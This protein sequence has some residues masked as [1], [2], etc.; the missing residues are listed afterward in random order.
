MLTDGVYH[1][2]ISATTTVLH[3]VALPQSTKYMINN[4]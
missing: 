3:R 1:A 4:R 2:T